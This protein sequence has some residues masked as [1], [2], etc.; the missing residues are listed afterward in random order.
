MSSDIAQFLHIDQT[1]VCGATLSW[2]W[3]KHIGIWTISQKAQK[4]YYTINK[5]GIY[6]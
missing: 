4:K 5:K 6:D 1:S 3:S 2:L